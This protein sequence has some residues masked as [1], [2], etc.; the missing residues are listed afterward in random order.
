MTTV[1]ASVVSCILAAQP[2]NAHLANGIYVV[3]RSGEGTTVDRSDGGGTVVF[4]ALASTAFGKASL[5]SVSN[6]NSKYRLD[7]TGAGPF[8]SGAENHHYAIYV[9]GVCVLVWGNSAPHADHTMDLELTINGE[10]PAEKIAKALGVKPV[11]RH[12]PGH[13]LVVAW[14]P[15]TASSTKRQPVVVRMEIKKC[16]PSP[17]TF[18]RRWTPA[19]TS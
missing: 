4:G 8:S 1:L 7:L 15:V 14:H 2:A 3:L 16:G 13:Q 10:T 18:R 5:T 17:H 19:R 11:L 12:H 9:D 6:D